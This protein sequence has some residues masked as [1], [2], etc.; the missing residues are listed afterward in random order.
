MLMVNL[1]DYSSGKS[2]STTIQ[3]RTGVSQEKFPQRYFA[4]MHQKNSQSTH[5]GFQWTDSSNT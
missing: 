4:A 3:F 1:C 2:D 5:A